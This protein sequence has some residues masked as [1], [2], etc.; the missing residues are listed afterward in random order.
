MR[1]HHW[2]LLTLLGVALL[3]AVGDRATRQAASA[4]PIHVKQATAGGDDGTSWA[5]AYDDLQDALEAAVSGDQIWVAAGTY[6]PSDAPDDDVDP[7]ALSFAL[8]D[9]VGLYGGFAGTE[10]ALEQRDFEANV[11]TL[12]GDINVDVTAADNAYHVVV[13]SGVTDTA[14]LDGF[15]IRAGQA[16]GPPGVKRRGAGIFISGGSPTLRNLVVRNNNAIDGGGGIMVT[17]T[18]D[19]T[20]TDSRFID[21]DSASST[22]GGIRVN[23]SSLTLE[24]LYFNLNTGNFG[25]AIAQVNSQTLVRDTTFEGNTSLT[26]GGAINMAGSTAVF[27]RVAFIGNN[28]VNIAGAIN[29]LSGTLEVRDST[30]SGN[31]ASSS[32][33]IRIT[34]GTA[35]IENT[36]IAFN[37]AGAGNA[38]IGR[39]SAG[40]ATIRNSIIWGNSTPQADADSAA[41]ITIA[42]SIVQGGCPAN[43]TCTAGTII[44]AD[45]L[46][47]IAAEDHGSTPTHPLFP[48]SPAID[49]GNPLTCTD[50]DQRGVARPQDGDAVAGAVCDLGAYEFLKTPVVQFDTSTSSGEESVSPVFGVSLSGISLD[51]VTVEYAVTGGTATSGVDFTLA[52]GTLTFAPGDTAESI[53]LAVADDALPEG[54]ETVVVE[55]SP[56][57]EG[58]TLGARATH[59]HTIATSDTPKCAGRTATI[60]GTSGNDT[61]TGTNGPDVIA[62]LDGDDTVNARGGD[63]VVCGGEGDDTIG[64]GGGNDRLLGEAGDDRLNGNGGNDRIVAGAGN[65]R[66]A[67]QTGLDRLFGSGGNDNLNGGGG[68]DRL[69]GGSGNDQARGGPGNDTLRG[70]AGNDLL[71]GSIGNDD[72]DGGIGKDRGNGERGKDRVAGGAGPDLLAGGPDAGDICAGGPGPDALLPNHGCETTTGVP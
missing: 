47:D 45:P 31:S 4:S 9:G 49:A 25:A 64:G 12:S 39:F 10:T 53:A 37:P 52:A 32:S 69:I 7:R 3:G 27:E 16:D 35:L 70:G 2:V 13:G 15:T 1:R 41:A 6:E 33:A 54:P 60:V 5:T 20:I 28:G 56:V 50:E 51:P 36:T 14:V 19:V 46:L 43:V 40:T 38:T 71:F 24:R 18:S 21:N 17:D 67:G 23:D 44:D 68:D 63:D 34:A 8:K 59:T 30:I 48:G 65:D 72:L 29:H 42:N 55:L 26:G 22:G 66:V 62:A 58:A 11:T 61:I 57:L